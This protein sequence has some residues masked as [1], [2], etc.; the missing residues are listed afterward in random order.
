[1]NKRNLTAA[2]LAGL[3]GAAGI[4]GTA[5]AVNISADGIGQ[6]LFYPYYTANGGNQTILS[7][8]NTTD[9]AKAVKVRFLEGY[10]SREVLDFNLYLSK[11]DVWAAAVADSSAFGLD[12]G[13]PHL[14]IRDNSC[15]VPYL[16]K[17]KFDESVGAALQ[18]FLNLGY[19][20]SANDGGPESIA[21][22]AEGHFEI[23][24]MGTVVAG[25]DTEADITH[26]LKNVLDDDDEVV[27]TV[28][29][30][31]D[32]EQLVENW[33][34]FVPPVDGKGIWF[35]EATSQEGCDI[36][37]GDNCVAST[38]IDRN[39]GGLFGGGAVVNT[40]NGTMFGYNA[41]ALQGFDKNVDGLTLHFLPGN[42]HPSLNDGDQTNAFVFFGVPQNKSVE[43][44]YSLSADAVSAVLMHDTIFN[45]YVTDPD[46]AAATEWVVT[47]PTKNFYV[48]P[49]QLAQ[50]PTTA[51]IP[52]SEDEG[53]NGWTEGSGIPFPTTKP[54]TGL[55]IDGPGPWNNDGWEDCS[56]V[57][58][59]TFVD[60][61]SAR[62]P[63][64]NLF[65]GES[66]ELVSLKTWDRDERTFEED[67][68]GSRPPVVSPSVPDDCDP[69]LQI[70]DTTPFE[71]CFET[72]VLRFGDDSIFATPEIE[73]QSLLITID[74]EFTDGWGRIDFSANNQRD[75]N[76]MLG[77]PVTGFA[78][79][80]FENEFV[81]DDDVKAF[82]GGLFRHRASTR[83]VS[84]QSDK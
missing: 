11:H 27:G 54:G 59:E 29:E 16:Y 32:C 22:A 41:V 38:D 67:L 47:F 37:V 82:Y 24:E 9:S 19:A 26:T 18:P 48:D 10:N 83:K 77:L 3:A 30:P 42:I 78:A 55:P 25:S 8:V 6:V 40:D 57:E 13:T 39:S 20:G 33:T 63:F 28:W 62:L 58:T 73:G 76:G 64:S 52:N 35:K 71:L 12:A 61:N 53:C 68:G 34:E 7:V 2:V 56:Y 46:L 15:T 75:S 23:I 43:L 80:E 45:E 17:D 36:G 60:P 4:A 81:G 66:C 31:G 65:N 79:W 51:W 70:C 21:R 69:T 74:N 5:Q 84:V 72:N 14:A 44:G 50:V 49:D 1:M